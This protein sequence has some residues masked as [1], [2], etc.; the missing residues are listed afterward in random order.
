MACDSADGNS[1]NNTP[2][3]LALE[4]PPTDSSA[5]CPVPVWVTDL[6]AKRS[7]S[8]LPKRRQTGREHLRDSL[9][10][11]CFPSVLENTDK[12][13]PGSCSCWGKAGFL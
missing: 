4:L 3:V 12:S 7:H 6:E 11:C 13:S 10:F 2:R 9:C 8:K 5:E 1:F